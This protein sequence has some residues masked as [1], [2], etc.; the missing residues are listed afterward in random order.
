MYALVLEANFLSVIWN[1]VRHEMY[2]MKCLLHDRSQGQ[3]HLKSD[4]SRAHLGVVYTFV[5]RWVNVSG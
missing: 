3:A 4:V 2:D 1:G 5:E